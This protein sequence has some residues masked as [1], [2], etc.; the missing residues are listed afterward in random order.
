MQ[1]EV[2]DNPRPPLLTYYQPFKEP[3]NA[4]HSRPSSVCIYTHRQVAKGPAPCLCTQFHSYYKKKVVSKQ[5]SLADN[6]CQNLQ[7]CHLHHRYI[8]LVTWEEHK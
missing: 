5:A 6:Q 3:T 7:L 1:Q 8:Q 2:T 4:I